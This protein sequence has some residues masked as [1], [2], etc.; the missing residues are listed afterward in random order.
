MME[1][2]LRVSDSDCYGTTS[3]VAVAVAVAVAIAA[4]AAI[5]V[6]ES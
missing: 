5:A 4:V 2:M 6:V 3:A 1:V